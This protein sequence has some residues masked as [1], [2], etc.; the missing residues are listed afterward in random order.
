MELVLLEYT[1][2]TLR[3]V[4]GLKKQDPERYYRFFFFIQEKM[5]KEQK[6]LDKLKPG[7]SS[8]SDTFVI[9]EKGEIE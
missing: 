5:K 4:D 8:E 7:V 9:K 6:Q 1:S 2:M 3:E